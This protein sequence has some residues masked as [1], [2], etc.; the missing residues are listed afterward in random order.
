MLTQRNLAAN[1]VATTDQIGP[2]EDDLRLG[3]LPLS[4]IYAR[5]CDLYSWIYHG[6]R[7]VL[8]E[9]RETVFRDL[10]LV[11][12]TVINAVPY[13][14][15]KV[16]DELRMRGGAEDEAALREL[17]GGRIRLCLC[18][19]AALAPEVDRFFAERG[20]P[21]LCGYGLTEASPVISIST[22]DTYV[23][24]TVGR[25]LANLEIRLAEDGEVQVRGESVMRGYWRDEEATAAAI[26]D[27]W[28]KTGDLGAFDSDGSLRIVGRKK[29][30]L[31]LATG[32][33]V[34]PTQVETLLAGSPLV[35]Q[36]CVL[37][38]GR[39][40]LAALIVP[41][42]DAIRKE[43]RE[44]RLWVW[45]KRRAVTHPKVKALYRAEIDRCLSQIGHCE[46]IGQF[47][48]LPRAFSQD[49]GELTAKL[50]LRREVIAKNFAREIEGMYSAH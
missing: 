43:I 44:R 12:P 5:T 50:S 47:V 19:G 16:V 18:G 39:K 17:F 2:D 27:G 15:Q 38:D 4:H 26:E 41:N 20:L 21:I 22:A 28:L 45:S 31:V 30:L 40:F 6:G 10:G 37:G 48:I 29:E 14:Y 35:E 32:K 9:S 33:K 7:F 11:Q 49:L 42:G 36:A 1:A 23:S 8:A 34:A 24:G 25:P 46:Q 3:I 13:F